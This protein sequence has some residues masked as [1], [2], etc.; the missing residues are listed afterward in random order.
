MLL[1]WSP[2]CYFQHYV[3]F[4]NNVPTRDSW[5]C[6]LFFTTSCLKE[7]IY[8]LIVFCSNL[9]TVATVVDFHTTHFL[10]KRFSIA[11]KGVLFL[12]SW[13][14]SV[15]ELSNLD[16]YSSALKIKGV[17]LFTAIRAVK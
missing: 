6:I 5:T 11:I 13:Y 4:R 15:V 7:H 16:I 17:T 9:I 1:P 10:E 3:L 12:E 2:V 8:E 14:G